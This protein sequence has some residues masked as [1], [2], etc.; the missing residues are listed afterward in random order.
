MIHL[1]LFTKDRFLIY[2]SFMLTKSDL[3]KIA[4]LISSSFNDPENSLRKDFESFRKE[5]KND[6]VTFKDEILGE[7]RGL[8]DEVT[9]VTGYKDQ[10]VF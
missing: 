4:K 3:E 2:D 5:V 10:L 8:R 9:I 7:I 1:R 6:I